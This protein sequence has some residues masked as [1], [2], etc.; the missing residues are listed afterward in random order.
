MVAVPIPTAVRTPS[1]TVTTFT[2]DDVHTIAS[3]VSAGVTVYSTSTD[4]FPVMLIL[5]V[6][7]LSPVQGLSANVIVVTLFAEKS[8]PFLL[9][10]YL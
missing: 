1:D 7:K 10:L 9:V 3:V 6:A 5:S 8:A 2:S 4:S